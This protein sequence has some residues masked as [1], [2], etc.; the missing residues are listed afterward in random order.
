L[1]PIRPCLPPALIRGGFVIASLLFAAGCSL[2]PWKH[3]DPSPRPGP[4]APGT[5]TTASARAARAP[6]SAKP[7]PRPAPDPASRPAGADSSLRVSVPMSAGER[8][9]LEAAYESDVRAADSLV[10]LLGV[11]RAQAK[12]KDEIAAMRGLITE[13]RDE[14][15]R[16]DWSGA[17]N[18]ARKARLI[19]EDEVAATRGGP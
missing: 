14:H 2:V 16:E 10:T 18:L 11:L 13:A 6:D 7:A 9:S 12:S 3:H 17:A 1:T 8:D 5:R 4:D 15:A 19:A